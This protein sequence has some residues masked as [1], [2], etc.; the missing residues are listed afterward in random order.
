[1][2]GQPKLPPK[3]GALRKRQAVERA[4]DIA[5]PPEIISKDRKSCRRNFIRFCKVYLPNMFPLPDSDD[6]ID[7]K[8]RIEHAVLK[9]GRHAEAAPRGDGKTQRAKA[10]AI[11]AA[12]YG[13]WRYGV[14]LAATEKKGKQLMK[15]IAQELADNERLRRDWPGICIPMREAF[16]NANRARAITIN[17]QPARMECSTA[18]IV[19]PTWDGAAIDLGGTVIEGAGILAAMRGLRYTT[20]NGETLRPD[21]VLIDDIQTRKS[22]S[23]MEQCE[24]RLATICGD[25]MKLAGPDKE[26]SAVCMVTVIKRGD[27]ADQLL[28]NKLHPEWRGVRKK[29]VY[30]WPMAEARW[31]EYATLRRSG[32]LA[33]DGGAPAT[34]FYKAHQVEMDNQAR[35]GWKF[36]FRKET[37]EIS[38]LQC[39]YNI[40]IDDGEEAFWAECQNEPIEHKAEVYEIKPDMV[41]SRLNSLEPGVALMGSRCLTTF[42]D[43]NKGFLWWAVCGWAGEMTGNVMAYG[44]W[45]A[46][47]SKFWD[48]KEPK[49]ETEQQAI[50]RALTELGGH[51]TRMGAFMRDGQPMR[52]DCWMIDIGYNDK[53]VYQFAESAQFP[54]MIRPSR[55]WSSRTYRPVDAKMVGD[56]WHRNENYGKSGKWV[57]VHDAD[58]QRMQTQQA[59]LLPTGSPGGITL[60][61]GSALVHKEFAK[62]I[63]AERLAEHIRGDRFDHYHW[64]QV[65]GQR[66]EALDCVVGCR[67]GGLYVLGVSGQIT[68]GAP[69]VKQEPAE[70]KPPEPVKV[71]LSPPLRPDL[72]TEQTGPVSYESGWS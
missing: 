50:Y 58:W 28:N 70:Q 5:I 16:L 34:E 68:A 23:S 43:I 14:V 69:A 3:S 45:P 54:T 62:S 10:G 37:G 24:Q 40:L 66:N 12:L 55:G 21:G 61:G 38:P 20:A 33:G 39:A 13:H 72:R 36:R 8:K 48:E 7:S 51:L 56:H 9:G 57:I 30:E 2:I 60:S 19:F 27:A 4:A 53:A 11:W 67:V 1:M 44:P 32:L 25:V 35:V 71:E 6:Q 42:T 63:C 47:G 64:E 26:I 52:L 22:A 31:K 65:P 29:M 17:G 18:R 15:E 49:G 59:F 46:D 41:A